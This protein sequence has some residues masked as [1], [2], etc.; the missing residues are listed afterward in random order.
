MPPLPEGFYLS[1]IYSA[2]SNSC[3]F[4]YDNR[5]KLFGK[6]SVFNYSNQQ[7]AIDCS[8]NASL[9]I[10]L[11]PDYLTERKW[12]PPLL[13]RRSPNEVLVKQ[14]QQLLD[15]KLNRVRNASKIHITISEDEVFT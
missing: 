8:L 13:L 4:D 6:H 15:D 1:R 12:I 10:V 5:V 7:L 14:R 3:L 2:F 11:S 9:S